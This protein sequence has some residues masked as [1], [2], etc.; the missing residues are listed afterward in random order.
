VLKHNGGYYGIRL[1]ELRP[2][3]LRKSPKRLHYNAVRFRAFHAPSIYID[4][5]QDPPVEE[6]KV[7]GTNMLVSMP[8]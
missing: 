8:I 1:G 7:S 6:R 3:A 2:R 5:S 4:V